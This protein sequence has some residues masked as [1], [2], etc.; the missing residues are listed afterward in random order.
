MPTQG[1]LKRYTHLCLSSHLKHFLNEL[2]IGAVVLRL[3]R[4]CQAHVLLGLLPCSALYGDT[5]KVMRS[6]LTPACGKKASAHVLDRSGRIKCRM[7]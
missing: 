2:F 5:I 1:R 6:V 4:R 7:F 3:F